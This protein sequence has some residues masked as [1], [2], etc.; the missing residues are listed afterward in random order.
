MNNPHNCQAASRILRL[1]YPEK[2]SCK[3]HLVNVE[4]Q[5]GPNDCG[6]F[7]IA[8]AQ[9]LSYGIDPFKYKF[10]QSKMRLTYNFFY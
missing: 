3:V 10:D 2:I 5:N 8:Y 6:L 1:F 4:P 9:M 7:A